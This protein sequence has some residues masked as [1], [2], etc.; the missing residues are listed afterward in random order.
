MTINNRIALIMS[1][2]NLNKNQMALRLGVHATVIHNIVDPKGRGNYP[3][4]DL[5]SK[6]LSTFDDINGDW[7]IQGR[8]EMNI[9]NARKDARKDAPQEPKVKKYDMPNNTDIQ[10]NESNEKYAKPNIKKT[11]RLIPYYDIDFM[12]GTAAV[13]DNGHE[14][15]SYFIDINP[16]SDCDFAIPIFG[17]S[18]YPIYQNGDIVLCRKVEDKSIIPLGEAYLIVTREHR[19]LKYLDDSKKEG[20]LTAVSENSERYKPF[21]IEVDKILKLYIV[22]GVIK[23]RNI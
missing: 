17:D 16:F 15:P 12:A 10:L 7:L 4:Y 1:T 14:V 22:K 8:G 23:R 19:M 3:S 13:F 5:I 21:S 9:N 20:C 18:M 6:I 2:H 11:A